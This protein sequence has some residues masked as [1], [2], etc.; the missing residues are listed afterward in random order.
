MNKKLLEIRWKL[1]NY[2][3]F[4]YICSG[5]KNSAINLYD[6]ELIKKLRNIYY[7]GIPA[8]IILLSDN[9]S[10][11]H[12][13]DRALLMARAFL[14]TEDDINLI[15]AKVNS[16]KYNPNYIDKN[17]PLY[18]EHCFVERITK[19][20]KHLIYDTSLG[21]VFDK[22]LYWKME[23]PIVRY[24]NNKKSIIKF[25]ESDEYYKEGIEINK[26]AASMLIPSIEMSY[27]GQ[28]ELYSYSEIG[29]LQREIKHFKNEI[30]Y[31]DV[32][33]EINEDMKRW[34]YKK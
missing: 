30:D 26:Y 32:C 24:I 1:H 2:K 9:M 23:H 6:D 14:D 10:N 27:G 28:Y 18:A 16:L 8:S 5:L 12:C 19:E 13:Y 29:L 4:L 15:Y 31:D 20:G 7:K 21:F 25:V 17:N 11:G 22:E 3:C 33:K 34:E